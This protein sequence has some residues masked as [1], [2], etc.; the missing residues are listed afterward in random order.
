M[1]RERAKQL[2]PMLKAFGDGEDIQW[3]GCLDLR[4]SDDEWATMPTDPLLIT[5]FPADDYEYRIKPKPREWWIKASDIPASGCFGTNVYITDT[6]GNPAERF[7]KVREV[8]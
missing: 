7:I 4:G 8:L 3:R 5:T 6:K 2:A 1:N